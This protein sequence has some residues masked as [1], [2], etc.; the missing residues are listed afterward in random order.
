M[1]A[2]EITDTGYIVHRKRLRETSLLL[3]IFTRQHG[4]VSVIARGAL[5]S[6]KGGGS[7]YAEFMPYF[8]GWSGKSDLPTL[9]RAEPT[10]RGHRLQA[11]RL[12]S[13]MYLNE[14]VMRLVQRGDGDAAGYH[15]Y[16]LTVQALAGDAPLEPTL[17]HFEALLL[18]ACGYGVELAQAVDTGHALAVEV[19]YYYVPERG[20]VTQLPPVPHRTVTGGA[21]LALA[22]T[23]PW[24]VVRL[25]EA[26]GLMRFL[27]HYHLGGQAVS[28]RELFRFS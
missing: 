28:S 1:A 7:A 15:A 22:G 25:R 6:K 14:L 18:A 24:D 27:L 11:E 21:L 26:K 10:A 16:E 9:I 13:A 17:R 19:S 3:Q 20:P 2:R 4:R 12:F 23:L 5:A 8:F